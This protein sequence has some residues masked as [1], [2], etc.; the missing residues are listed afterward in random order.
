MKKILIFIIVMLLH[1]GFCSNISKAANYNNDE[2]AQRMSK[3]K[4]VVKLFK[5]S[6]AKKI[7]EEMSVENTKNGISTSAEDK[8]EFDK[9]CSRATIAWQ[10]VITKYPE[11]NNLPINEKTDVIRAVAELRFGEIWSCLNSHIT[12]DCGLVFTFAWQQAAYWTCM[13]IS[14][15]AD[16]LFVVETAGIGA[17][18]LAPLVTT[19]ASSCYLFSTG[20][21]ATACG[22][23]VITKT[24]NCLK[25]E[26]AD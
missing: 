9:L 25:A 13:G 26:A 12:S 16:I 4:D 11:F 20:V 18:A 1:N 10:T 6:I 15:V 7:S 22:V 17:T 24:L 21:A 19:Q 5:L 23:S 8:V 2:L 3:D 14:A